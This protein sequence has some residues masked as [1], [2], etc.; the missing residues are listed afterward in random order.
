MVKNL[1]SCHEQVKDLGKFVKAAA[2]TQHTFHWATSRHRASWNGKW[3]DFHTWENMLK[4]EAHLQDF[5]PWSSW[6]LRNKRFCEF[7]FLLPSLWEIQ[8]DEELDVR[9]KGQTWDGEF[10]DSDSDSEGFEHHANHRALASSEPAFPRLSL[11]LYFSW[12]SSIHVSLSVDKQKLPYKVSLKCIALLGLFIA[13]DFHSWLQ[14]DW[15][16]TIMWRKKWLEMTGLQMKGLLQSLQVYHAR[17][18]FLTHWRQ[19][20]H[21]ALCFLAIQLQCLYCRVLL[22]LH[23]RNWL[24]TLDA[25]K[26]HVCRM[27]K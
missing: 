4:H 19:N 27:K 14:W 10:S 16:L 13:G 3:V 17:L 9:D 23:G 11:L 20:D 21:G 1:S 22:S 6:G 2:C 15:L 24:W 18:G 12:P 8:E 5:I 26:P 25:A 7:E